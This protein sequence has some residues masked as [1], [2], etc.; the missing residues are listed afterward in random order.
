MN[1]ETI[2]LL[3]RARRALAQNPDN[4]ALAQ[5]IAGVEA[6]VR[7]GDQ[8]ALADSADTLLDLLYELEEE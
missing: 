7:D 5:A 4:S 3:T 2:H 1:L 8:A 6:T